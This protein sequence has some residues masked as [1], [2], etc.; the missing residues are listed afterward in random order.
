MPVMVTATPES[1]IFP[2]LS[3]RIAD[4]FESIC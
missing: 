2:G 4:I 1:P 3:L